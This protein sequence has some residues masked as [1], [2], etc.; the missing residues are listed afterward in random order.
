[1]KSEDSNNCATLPWLGQTCIKLFGC[2]AKILTL[3]G[4]MSQYTCKPYKLITNTI[5]RLKQ[6]A[7]VDYIMQQ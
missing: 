5:I 1:M 3:F 6:Q 2:R 7:L 4:G